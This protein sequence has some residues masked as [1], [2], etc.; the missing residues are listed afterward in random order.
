M[1]STVRS[2]WGKTWSV[3]APLACLAG[4]ALVVLLTA[5][6][7]AND[8]VRSIDIGEVPAATTVPAI[9]AVA[10]GL[11][12]GQLVFAAFAVQLVAPEYATGLIRVTLQAQPRRHVVV[13]AK[14]IVAAV[15][16]LLVGAALGALAVATASAL[17]GQQ[18]APGAP[19][20]Q[21]AIRAACMLGLVG[22]LVV[23]LGAA[24][25]SGVGTL[26]AAA[27]VL[28]GTLALPGGAG[29][30]T[31]GPAAAALMEGSGEPYSS[32]VGLAV[33]AAWA[34]AG[35]ALGCRIMERR[36]A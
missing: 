14:A 19:T 29:R 6:S 25:R 13:L 28:I 22:P 9:D 35:V 34:V 5:A 23:G 3:R 20:A 24:L 1:R 21:T 27:V 30:W 7:L 10:P 11:Q 31:P 36:D 15:C 18:L 12:F 32:E 26:S 17:L 8:A 2:E 4:T 16:G 33:L